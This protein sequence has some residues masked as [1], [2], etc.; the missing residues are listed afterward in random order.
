MSKET[1]RRHSKDTSKTKALFD[2][3]EEAFYLQVW[4]SELK[5]IFKAF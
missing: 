4:S 2:I 3:T 1:M 5:V